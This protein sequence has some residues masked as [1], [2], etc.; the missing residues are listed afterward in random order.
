MKH[1]FPVLG[2]LVISLVL[3]V[4]FHRYGLSR[5]TEGRRG[6]TIQSLELLVCDIKLLHEGNVTEATKQL[7]GLVDLLAVEA[8]VMVGEKKLSKNEEQ[9]LRLWLEH[10]KMYPSPSTGEVARAVKRATNHISM[11]LEGNK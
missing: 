6:S 3:Y 5:W 4:V 11:F 9:A 8:A 10:R 2:I 7:E 1:A